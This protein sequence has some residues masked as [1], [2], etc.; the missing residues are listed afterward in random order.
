MSIAQSVLW[1]IVSG[2]RGGMRL[3]EFVHER[4]GTDVPEPPCAFV[5]VSMMPGRTVRRTSLLMPCAT[6]SISR[7]R[8]VICSS[9][10]ETAQAIHTCERRQ[11]S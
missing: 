10:Q 6:E 7:S 5:G 4:I 3:K 2:G 1:S 11:I 8:G 9:L